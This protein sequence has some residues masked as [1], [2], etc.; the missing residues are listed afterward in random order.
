MPAHVPVRRTTA[1]RA[2]FHP[3]AA[4][5]A[6]DTAGIAVSQ[7][8]LAP[9][10]FASPA[11]VIAAPVL[12]GLAWVFANPVGAATTATT[13]AAVGA[14]PFTDGNCNLVVQ[15]DAARAATGPTDAGNAN[16]R[17]CVLANPVGNTTAL[18]GLSGAGIT[19][20]PACRPANPVGT[21]TT[22][23]TGA[24]AAATPVTVANCDLAVQGGAAWGTAGLAGAGITTGQACMLAN[25]VG[26]ATITAATGA[27]AAATPVTDDNCDLALQG[28]A[29][30]AATGLTGAG[31][32][33]GI[34]SDSFNVLGGMAADVADGD[35]PANVDILKEGPAGSHDEGR[36]MA[37][38]IHRIA[39]GAQIDFYTATDG[40]ADFAAGVT[41]LQA[42]GCSVI[43]DDV[44]YLDEPFFQDTG[45]VDTAIQTAVA[46][47]VSYFTAAG[48][49]GQDFVEQSFAPMR[50]TLPGLPAGASVQNFGSAAA[51]RPWVN[52]TVPTG[53]VAMLDLQWDQPF[54][55]DDSPG[56]ADSLGMALYNSAGEVVATATADT[57]GDD[58]VQLLTYANTSASSQFRL[59]LYANGGTVPPSEFKVIAYGSASLSGAEVGDGSG[60]VIGHEMLADVNTVGAIAYSATPAFGGS[61]TVEPYSSVGTGTFLL[62]PSGNALSTPQ[63]DD[64]V[65]F[66]APDGSVTSTLAPF[67]GTSAAAANAAAVAAL[68]QQA[69]PWLTPAQLTRV[70]EQSAVPVNGSADAV[71]AGLIQAN[72]AVQIALGLAHTTVG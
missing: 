14:T 25:P 7:L 44:A 45:A 35:L 19:T 15:G 33:I 34:L 58:P 36:A 28:D 37:E 71:G 30:R 62:N 41:A 66:L 54:A 11:A 13:D 6:A 57:V 48:N 2:A 22:A 20:G 70:L 3:I 40:Q 31:I 67:Y 60:T 1:V 21:S 63:T 12:P 65:D 43:V 8:A 4:A 59:V 69:D 51:P 24:T 23:A 68:V 53:G 50:L 9:P 18:T 47:G 10:T 5:A 32:T 26:T 56:S 39:P 52:V 38:L 46:S 72:T 61:D 17:A 55:G 49:Q 27:T 29:A 42:A 16:G 64:K